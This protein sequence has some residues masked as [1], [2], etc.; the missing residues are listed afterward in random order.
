MTCPRLHPR[1]RSGIT[2]TEILISILIMGIGLIS[3]ATLFPI[4]LERI[5]AATRNTRS[6]LL[7]EAAAADLPARNLLGTETFLSAGWYGLRDPFIQDLPLP[8]AGV[9]GGVYRGWGSG[10]NAIY[11]PGSGLPVC[12]DPLWWAI[13]YSRDNNITPLTQPARFGAAVFDPTGAGPS[14]VRDDPSGGKASAYG[15]QRLTNFAAGTLPLALDAFCS[16]DDPVLQIEGDLNLAAGSGSPILPQLVTDPNTNLTSMVFDWTFSWIFTGKKT[17]V[18]NGTVFDGD[19]VIFH[20]RPFALDP[21]GATSYFQAS[22]ERVVEA[23]FA[24]GTTVTMPG[25]AN[26]GVGYSPRDRSVLLRWP[27]NQPDPDVR[28]GGWIADVTYEQNTATSNARFYDDPTLV[29]TPV[30]SGTPI[31]RT[32][33][34]QR[35]HWYRVAKKGEAEDDPQ[36]PGHR[37][38]LITTETPVQSRT[39]IFGGTGLPVHVNVA[40][41]SPY[42]VNVFPK[43]IYAR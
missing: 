35:C 22:G 4:G 30:V 8:T 14:L 6:A 13:V 2:L 37:R 33:P 43:V 41:V 25:V 15:L 5:R 10:G 1:D 34:G 32:Y 19:V 36:V 26:P 31:T 9:P 42:V 29:A 38:M 18:S 12:Y 24:Y 21:V 20:N 11:R 27:A 3:L 39:L 23:V 28:V 16:P 17:D 40:L 7:V